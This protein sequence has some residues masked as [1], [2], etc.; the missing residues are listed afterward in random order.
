MK[1]NT[2]YKLIPMF[3]EDL[4]TGYLWIN[5]TEHPVADSQDEK[6]DLYHEWYE[7]FVDYGF[8][9]AHF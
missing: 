1:F 4:T 9:W 7:W 6:S 5:F 2:L 3:T 8:R